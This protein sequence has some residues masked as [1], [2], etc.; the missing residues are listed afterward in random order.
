[1]EHQDLYKTLEVTPES[2]IE[3]IK[4]SYKRLVKRYHP[5]LS[6]SVNANIIFDNIK[7]AYDILSDPERRKLY[8]ET[9]STQEVSYEVKK[10]YYKTVFDQLICEIIY[11]AE[12]PTI[13][14]LVEKMNEV[15]M[16]MQKKSREL[17][18]KIN[19]LTKFKNK[20]QK[21]EKHN[22]EFFYENFVFKIEELKQQKTTVDV[23]LAMYDELIKEIFENHGF[24]YSDEIFG[25]MLGY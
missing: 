6:K 1:M 8:D 10:T 21:K 18:K 20:I 19:K 22:P 25:H 16:N 3:E 5:D 13:N 7:K 9:G 17:N 2:T 24:T 23:E 15:H 4:A 14:I 11:Q 12:N